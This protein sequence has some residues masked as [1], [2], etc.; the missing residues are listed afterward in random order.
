MLKSTDDKEIQ[1]ALK[2]QSNYIAIVIR[3]AIE[4]FH[5][6]QFTNSQM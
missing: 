4:K 5:T 1:E 6:E 2:F 3:N